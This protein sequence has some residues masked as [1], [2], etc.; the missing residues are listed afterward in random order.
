MVS[1]LIIKCILSKNSDRA[2]EIGR[3][4]KTEIR[5]TW[6][7]DTLNRRSPAH[8][9]LFRGLDER[10]LA[11]LAASSSI[12]PF[13]LGSVIKTGFVKAISISGDTLAV[14]GITH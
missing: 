8:R 5:I 1:A 13:I 4:D 6:T 3:R 9:P 10:E 11:T 14:A 12:S 7:V 2:V